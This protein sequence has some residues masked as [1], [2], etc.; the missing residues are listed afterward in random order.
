MWVS[1][2]VPTVGNADRPADVQCR[3]RC[4]ESIL[5]YPGV[6]APLT[7]LGQVAAAL[8]ARRLCAP[9]DGV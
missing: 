3:I 7:D 1:C 8:G 9:R 2:Q 4:V 6:V 5:A